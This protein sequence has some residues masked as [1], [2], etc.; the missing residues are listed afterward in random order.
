MR[1]Q[2]SDHQN[3]LPHALFLPLTANAQQYGGK[4]QNSQQRRWSHGKQ[5]LLVCFSIDLAIKFV[6]I[7][8]CARSAPISGDNEV[9][10]S[11]SLLWSEHYAIHDERLFGV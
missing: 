6:R 3:E 11:P 10:D 4:G 1:S 7:L 5:I 2:K 8:L 9:F